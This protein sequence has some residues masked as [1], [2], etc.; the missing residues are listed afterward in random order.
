MH[1]ALASDNWVVGRWLGGWT[2]VAACEAAL[3]S[4][5]FAEPMTHTPID[6]ITAWFNDHDDGEFARPSR[7]HPFK[8]IGP[9]PSTQTILYTT[10]PQ[11]ILVPEDYE[12]EL[13]TGLI[14]R[15]GLPNEDDVAWLRVLAEN[16]VVCFVGDAD[17]VDLLVFTWL[18]SRINAKYAGVSDLL[19]TNIGVSW[20]DRVTIPLSESESE[21]LA[22][23]ADLCPDFRLLLG[24]QSA[25]LF[26]RGRKLELEAVTIF[27]RIAARTLVDAITRVP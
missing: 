5:P 26:D 7:T 4:E 10:K 2:L 22:L 20:N 21:A 15:Y 17:P 16:R 23:L 13:A 18:R 6:K 27:P 11:C 14:G 25:A 8:V 24:P 3:A 19:L 9:T 1:P 12:T